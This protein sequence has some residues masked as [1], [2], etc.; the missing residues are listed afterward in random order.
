MA[1]KAKGIRIADEIESEITKELL[2]EEAISMSRVPGIVLMDGATGSRD[3]LAGTGLDVW[4]IIDTWQE[5]GRS[6]EE[7]RE[8]YP[9]L[10]EAQL[11]AALAYY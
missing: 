11:R 6:F 3:A 9:W 4:E 7:L 8:N 2:E 1:S 5:G 10:T